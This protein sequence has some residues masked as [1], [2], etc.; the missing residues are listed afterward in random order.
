MKKLF[1][2][3]FCLLAGAQGTCAANQSPNASPWIYKT[4]PFFTTGTIAALSLIKKDPHFLRTIS[5]V[6]ATTFVPTQAYRIYFE[7]K[8]PLLTNTTQLKAPYKR[9]F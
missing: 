5:I 6:G 8:G 9:C 7:G 1:L 3:L 2:I 4:F